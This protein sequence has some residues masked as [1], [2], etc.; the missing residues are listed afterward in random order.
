MCSPKHDHLAEG[1][2]LP[3]FGLTVFKAVGYTWSLS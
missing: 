2:P 1:L 3:D